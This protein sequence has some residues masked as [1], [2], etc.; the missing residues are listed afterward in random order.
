M[1]RPYS[2]GRSS[3]GHARLYGPRI[4]GRGWRH[5]LFS[6]TCF[7]TVEEGGGGCLF[8]P[9]TYIVTDGEGGVLY[10]RGFP[11]RD[12]RNI[13]GQFPRQEWR[14]RVCAVGFEIRN[15]NEILQEAPF[16]ERGGQAIINQYHKWQPYLST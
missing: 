15:V 10:C 11:P 9:R 6:A 1:A 16:R 3:G 13:T 4:L 7:G 8:I 2:R 14:K 5:F 12:A